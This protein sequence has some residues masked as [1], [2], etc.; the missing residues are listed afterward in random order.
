[1]ENNKRRIYSTL[2]L[3]CYKA[4]EYGNIESNP[5]YHPSLI[6]W[7]LQCK[8]D[9]RVGG[10]YFAF[11]DILTVF[12]NMKLLTKWVVVIHSLLPKNGIFFGNNANL[13]NVIE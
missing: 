1:M 12:K 10:E 6:T 9:G 5:I 2:I 4:E 7:S 8:V 11:R 13:T 3:R